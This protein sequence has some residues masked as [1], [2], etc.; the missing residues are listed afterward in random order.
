M[1]IVNGR[2]ENWCDRIRD[3]MVTDKYVESSDP[4][5]LIYDTCVVQLPGSRLRSQPIC[6]GQRTRS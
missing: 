4:T 6:S 2:C 3:V 1:E 5:F